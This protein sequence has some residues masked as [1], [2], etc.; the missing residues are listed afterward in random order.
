MS[1]RTQDITRSQMQS[2]LSKMPENKFRI[3][4]NRMKVT[5][6]V[7]DEMLSTAML[8]NRQH[9]QDNVAYIISHITENSDDMKDRIYYAIGH[10]INDGT[11]SHYQLSQIANDTSRQSSE[12]L[13]LYI[14]LNSF[15][16]HALA[17]ATRY[18]IPNLPED[19]MGLMLTQAMVKHLTRQTVKASK[20][21]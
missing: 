3:P 13:S 11:I 12:L 6:I 4:R 19:E 18:E 16:L 21:K 17:Q 5:D 20:N 9:P 15:Y 2:L 14:S 8:Y 1:A 7:Y 10:K